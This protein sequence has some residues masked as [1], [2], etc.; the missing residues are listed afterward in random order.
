[1]EEHLPAVFGL[2]VNSVVGGVKAFF[3][4]LTDVHQCNHEVIQGLVFEGL[5]AHVIECFALMR[6]REDNEALLGNPDMAFYDS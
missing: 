4:Y 3:V 1:M 2:Y 5:Y 6:G